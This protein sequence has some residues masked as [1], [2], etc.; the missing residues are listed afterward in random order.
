MSRYNI[1]FPPIS[2]DDL[3][4]GTSNNTKKGGRTTKN[5]QPK[6]YEH[7]SANSSQRV[8]RQGGTGSFRGRGDSLHRGGINRQST[9]VKKTAI[10][11]DLEQI[12]EEDYIEE[13]Q[14]NVKRQKPKEAA[15]SKHELYLEEMRR[16]FRQQREQDA[17]DLR[18][19]SNQLMLNLRKDIVDS[20]NGLSEGYKINDKL[21]VYGSTKLSECDDLDIKSL[22]MVSATVMSPM[23]VE[24]AAA[25]R[26]A[27][28]GLF[29]AQ[30]NREEIRMLKDEQSKLKSQIANLE[31]ERTESN[32]R[33]KDAHEEARSL[34]LKAEYSTLDR[35]DLKNS[36]TVKEKTIAFLKE[37][38]QIG[39]EANKNK[40]FLDEKVIVNA[41]VM[42]AKGKELSFDSGKASIKI[43]FQLD[44]VSK[45][46]KIYELYNLMDAGSKE[47]LKAKIEPFKSRHKH[48]DDRSH[49]KHVKAAAEKNCLST[50][51]K[52]PDPP[53]YISNNP[54][55]FFDVQDTGMRY[56]NR[57]CSHQIRKRPQDPNDKKGIEFYN[58][59]MRKAKETIL[60]KFREHITNIVTE[61]KGDQYAQRVL[62]NLQEAA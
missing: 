36:K 56:V 13:I 15:K 49:A 31:R 40:N 27:D 14:E 35:W 54:D 23:I 21:T 16:E 37:V 53:F 41:Y 5:Q 7:P 25:Y 30:T 24:T 34:V 22:Q 6:Q 12:Q 57:Q 17:E 39:V 29:V 1:E 51:S 47:N 43:G 8:T 32:R 42:I 19:Q 52:Y 28:K 3:K 4:A 62:K 58:Q 59:R 9:K 11:E 10:K 50:N 46:E 55:S 45:K 20:I 18:A 33:I 26:T 60:T 44:S 48:A 38:P 2:T 61:A